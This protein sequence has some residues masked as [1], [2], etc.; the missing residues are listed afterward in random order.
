MAGIQQAFNQSLAL[1]AGGALAKRQTKAL[2]ASTPEAIATRQAQA[3][4]TKY[5]ILTGT[6]QESERPYTKMTESELRGDLEL[7]QQA[8]GYLKEAYEIQ[9]TKERAETLQNITEQR[10]ESIKDVEAELLRRK[11]NREKNIRN[12]KEALEIR[13]SILKGTPSEYLLGGNK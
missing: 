10:H 2:E 6:R 13:K 7:N 5:D 3:E 11:E 12:Q 8:L 1:I 4:E 9:P